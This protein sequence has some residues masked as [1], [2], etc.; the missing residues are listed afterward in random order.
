MAA[1]NSAA[2]NRYRDV[3][4]ERSSGN[5]EQ[6]NPV[7]GNECN[8]GGKN[9]SRHNYNRTCYPEGD[10]EIRENSYLYDRRESPGDN[11][12]DRRHQPAGPSKKEVMRLQR[13]LELIKGSGSS[14]LSQVVLLSDVIVS[15]RLRGVLRKLHPLFSQ[16]LR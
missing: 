15:N 12:N 2:E 4:Q 3:V 9:N 1:G 16:I 5:R 7:P 14:F 11:Q 8:S 13:Q 10:T 6:T